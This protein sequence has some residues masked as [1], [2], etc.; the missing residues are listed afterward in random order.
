MILMLELDD[1]DVLW[2]EISMIT[3][4]LWFYYL[5]HIFIQEVLTITVTISN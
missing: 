1:F 5:N 2:R 3:M 4:H